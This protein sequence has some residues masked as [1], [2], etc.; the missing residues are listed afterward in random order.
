MDGAA[1]TAVLVA[2]M[3]L[4]P[5][6]LADEFAFGAGDDPAHAAGRFNFYNARDLHV[7]DFPDVPYHR[8]F[9]S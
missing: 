8:A 2:E 9:P 3:R 7:A 6:D 5:F 1:Q 4:Q